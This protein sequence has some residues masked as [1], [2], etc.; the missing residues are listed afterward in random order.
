MKPPLKNYRTTNKITTFMQL[1]KALSS[2][3]VIYLQGLNRVVSTKFISNWRVITLQ[4][5]VD[6]GI[7]EVISK[8]E[9]QKQRIQGAI[10]LNT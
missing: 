1:W 4:K 9:I 2:N 10:T 3:R 7:Y 8:R 5:Y 6:L